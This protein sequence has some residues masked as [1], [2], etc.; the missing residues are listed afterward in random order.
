MMWTM[1]DLAVTGG[2]VCCPLL[3]VAMVVGW[4]L[5]VFVLAGLV[6]V[7]GE[8]LVAGLIVVMGLS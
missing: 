8:V 3:I 5:V 1:E 4:R 2:R 6:I 7:T